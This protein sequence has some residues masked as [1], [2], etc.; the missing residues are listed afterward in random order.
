MDPSR[1][2]WTI[3]RLEIERDIPWTQSDGDHVS[4]KFENAL[5][6]LPYSMVRVSNLDMMMFLLLRTRN[7]A[8]LG[9]HRYVIVSG[10]MVT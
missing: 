5:K 6:R 3:A 10:Q 7:V 9:C 2:R 1:T 8:R 4:E